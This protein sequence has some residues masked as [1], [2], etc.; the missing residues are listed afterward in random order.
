M[1]PLSPLPDHE[2]MGELHLMLNGVLMKTDL[3]Y[4]KIDNTMPSHDVI[5]GGDVV[6]VTPPHYV[7]K[8]VVELKPT[9]PEPPLEF[10]K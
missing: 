5:V 2:V 3:Y 10:F 1:A 9:R 8:A 7:V 6:R 4:L